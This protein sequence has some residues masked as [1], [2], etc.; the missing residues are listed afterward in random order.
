[1]VRP[2]G[3]S[4]VTAT[5]WR[6]QRYFESC[7]ESLPGK[8]GTYCLVPLRS[9]VCLAF[10]RERGWIAEDNEDV[11]EELIQAAIMNDP[12]WAEESLRFFLKEIKNIVV[13]PETLICIARKG[14]EPVLL[15]DLLIFYGVR[16]QI[17]CEVLRAA[18]GSICDDSSLMI[19]LLERSE[20]IELSEEVF[21]AAAGSGSRKVLQVLYDY[22]GMAEIPI[23]WL[24]LAL[25]HDT[26]NSGCDG[27]FSTSHRR[28][29]VDDLHLETAMSFTIMQ[30][31]TLVSFHWTSP[32]TIYAFRIHA[33]WALNFPKSPCQP[34]KDFR[35]VAIETL[36]CRQEQQ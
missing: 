31:F 34:R 8:R 35:K 10:F 4:A 30:A 20:S 17:T 7:R 21:K 22:C 19:S 2:R 23:K 28:L 18:A 25:L 26:I 9:F 32:L 3:D 12:Y 6:H 5:S 33:N 16:L 14:W 11:I 24:D 29:G 13:S 1:M 36:K 15:L 27:L